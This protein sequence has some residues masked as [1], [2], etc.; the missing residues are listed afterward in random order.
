MSEII[1]FTFTWLTTLIGIFLNYE[2]YRLYFMI[3]ITIILISV[4]KKIME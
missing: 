1:S 4:I 2:I 3:P